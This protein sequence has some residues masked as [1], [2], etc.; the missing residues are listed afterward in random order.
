V[1]WPQRKALRA[2]CLQHRSTLRTS[3]ARRSR[4]QTHCGERGFNARG[5]LARRQAE[6]PEAAWNWP[7]GQARQAGEARCGGA[8]RPGA[9]LEHAVE[10]DADAAVPL[11]QAR[12]AEAPAS[13]E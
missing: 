6:A 10:A 1:H 5:D 11:V 8:Y 13:A 2:A 4:L 12:Q 9:Q 7:A 3:S